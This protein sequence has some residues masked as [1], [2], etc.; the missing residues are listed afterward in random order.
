MTTNR[1][2]KSETPPPRKGSVFRA[3]EWA[4]MA[5]AGGHH[6][7]AVKWWEA[8]RKGWDDEHY[9]T[10][11]AAEYKKRVAEKRAGKRA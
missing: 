2:A 7:K 6:D 11:A 3:A 10:V 8:D 1:L 9:D 5:E 4:V